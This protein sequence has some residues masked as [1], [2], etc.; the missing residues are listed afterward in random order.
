MKSRLCFVL[1]LALCIP[2]ICLAAT[3]GDADIVVK[4][5]QEFKS[6]ADAYTSVAQKYALQLFALCATLEVVYLGIKAALGQSE[7]GETV[8]NFCI[9]LLACGLFLAVINNY[10]EW[11]RAII[12]GLSSVAGEMGQIENTSDTAFKKALELCSQMWEVIKEI[13][14]R[15]MGLIFG[16]II[17]LFIVIICFCLITAQVIFIKCEAYV[18]MAA[19]C[20]LVGLGG[21][22]FFRDYAVNVIKYILAVAFKLF[23]MQLVLGIGYTFMQ[24]AITPKPDFA[25]VCVIIGVSIVLLALVKALPDTVAGIIQ[26]SHIGSGP[27]VAAGMRT[28]GSLALAAGAGAVA[29]ARNV[30]L[31]AQTTKAQ[32]DSARESGEKPVGMVSGTLSNLWGGARDARHNKEARQSTVGSALRERL[33]MAKLSKTRSTKPESETSKAEN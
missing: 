20:I 17:A 9:S 5:V 15:Q 13:S 30:G 24:D 28:V 21:T 3:G 25:T 29:G 18:A 27:N 12:N 33:E 32:R 4:I 10:S 26:G 19:A 1:F 2:D 22:S 31:A 7:I 23:T 11:S 14:W 6:K 16:M 8:K